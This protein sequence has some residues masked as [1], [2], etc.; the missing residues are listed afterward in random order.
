MHQTS[1]NKIWFL[2]E[3]ADWTRLLAYRDV[4][5]LILSDR[6]LSFSGTKGSLVV[7]R[8]EE[9]QLGKQ[10]RDFVNDWI[11]ITHDG[12]KVA[13]FADGRMLGWAGIFGGT[14]KLYSLLQDKYR[15]ATA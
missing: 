7:E 8:I 10:G 1:F 5:E 2:P 6:A 13:Y 12:G 11:R 3:P 15:P 4:G 9:L 14:R